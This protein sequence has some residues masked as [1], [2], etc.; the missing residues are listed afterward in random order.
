M[1]FRYGDP[2]QVRDFVQGLHH[3]IEA[4]RSDDRFHLADHSSTSARSRS[5]HAYSNG[6]NRSV[7]IVDVIRPP[8]TTVA[9]GRWTSAPVPCESAIGRAPSAPGTARLG[10]GRGRGGGP[11]RAA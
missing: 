2:R 7:R 8:I 4:L 9:N 10:T 3:V 6:S 5:N 1:D 11:S